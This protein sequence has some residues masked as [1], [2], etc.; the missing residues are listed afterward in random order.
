MVSRPAEEFAEWRAK[1]RTREPGPAEM[2]AGLRLAAARKAQMLE[3]MASDPARAL[4]EAI[5]RSEYAALPEALKPYFERP[6]NE[7]ASLRVMPV[8]APGPE[9]EPVRTLLAGGKTYRASVT[10]RRKTQGSKE[11]TPLAGIT[12]DGRAVLRE[13]AFE[14]LGPDDLKVLGSLPSGQAD[15]D[16]DYAS[17]A[18]LGSGQVTAMAGG[19]LYHFASGEALDAFNVRLSALDDR[20]GPLAGSRVVLAS[21]GGSGSGDGGFPWDEAE[22][23]TYKLA[24][25]WTETPKKVFFIR[26]DFP[27]LPGPS[28]SEAQLEAILNGPVATS[29]AQ[30]SYGKTSITGEAS[31]MVVRMPQPY[32]YYTA[33]EKNDQLHADASAAYEAIAGLGSLGNYDIVGVHFSSISMTSDGGL[34]AGLAILGGTKMWIQGTIAYSTFV[35]ELGHTYGLHHASFWQTTNGTVLGP[36]ATLDEYGDPF[37]VMGSGQDVTVNHYSASGKSRLNWLTPA[38]I[39]GASSAGNSGIR[40]IYRFD[41]PGTTASPRA[42]LALIPSTAD[43]YWIGYRAG[44][45]SNSSLQNGAYITLQKDGIPQTLLLDLTPGSAGG[46][47]DCALPLGKTYSDPGGG[48]HITPVA[49]GGSGADAWLDVNLQVGSFTGNTAPTLSVNAPATAVA[50]QAVSL[51][52]TASDPD[53]DPLLYQWDFGDGNTALVNGTASTGH[54]WAG[55]GTFLVKVTANDMKGH[56]STA[57]AT[58]SIT[59]PIATWTS[60]PTPIVFDVI[61]YL[62]GRFIGTSSAGYYFSADGVNWERIFRG[63]SLN[64]SPGPMA[65]DGDVFVASSTSNYFYSRDGRLW[66]AAD[67]LPTQIRMTEMVSAPGKF[68]GVAKGYSLISANQGKSWQPYPIA[69]NPDLSGVA[70]G[71]GIFVAAGRTGDFFSGFA[72]LSPALYTSPD[73]MTWTRRALPATLPYTA[74]I[75]GVQFVDGAFY[76][77]GDQT[78]ILRSNDGLNWTVVLAASEVPNGSGGTMPIRSLTHAPGF[79]IAAAGSS[80]TFSNLF[81]VSLDGQTWTRGSAA[82]PGPNPLYADGRLVSAKTHG[83]SAS[84][85]FYSTGTLQPANQAPTATVDAPVTCAARV[86]VLFRSQAT[87]PDGDPLTLLWDFNDDTAMEKTASC[88][89][90]FLVGGTYQ[91]KFRA[92]DQRGGLTTVTKT[93]TVEDPLAS[94]TKL[95]ISPP[96][97]FRSMAAGGGRIA[98]VG[99]GGGY[100]ASSDGVTWTGGKLGAGDATSIEQV[101]HDGS[102]FVACGWDRVNNT[103]KGAI[104]TSPDGVTWTRRYQDGIELYSLA[105]GGGHYAAG[106]DN[107]TILTSSDGIT[108]SPVLG[109]S[110]QPGVFY[111]MAYGDGRFLAV[112]S[113]SSAGLAMTS[114]DGTTW[115]NTSSGFGSYHPYMV[116]EAFHTGDKFLCTASESQAGFTGDILSS[117]DQGATFKRT[118]AALSYLQCF[119][120]GNGVNLCC[121]MINASNPANMISSDGIVWRF[122]PNPPPQQRTGAAYFNGRFY[123]AGQDGTIWRSGEMAP[124]AGAGYAGWAASRFPEGGPLAGPDADFDGD[125]LPNL[126]EY[127]GGSDPRDAQDHGGFTA[128]VAGDFFTMSIPKAGGVGDVACHVEYSADLGAWSGQG[129]QVVEDSSERLVARV[130]AAGRRGFLRAVFSLK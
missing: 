68:V 95:T 61:H 55:G 102:Q 25:A 72:D 70:Y 40:R 114:P 26:V 64:Y 3:W 100:Q 60:V 88:Y 53:G 27:N 98:A 45:T 21:P 107:S 39:S 28:A 110:G 74:K 19:K 41:D 9:R 92:I 101:I 46:K 24:S 20:P 12:L 94:W 122:L 84:P 42:A 11:D 90:S 51:S 86:P 103:N 82:S 81:L 126:A 66:E 67:P 5:S 59:D 116:L 18:K 111:S 48:V 79:F 2:E 34:Y 35:H 89:H 108:W 69:G 37:D 93:V 115:T 33:G 16:R 118:G 58:I 8:C 127:A 50:R 52:V 22:D 113:R 78:G 7:V 43:S 47:N 63:G 73:G 75:S 31:P 96:S 85:V 54:L 23:E 30:M 76:A 36:P 65:Y 91:V 105:A 129:V 119:A 57:S 104:Y 87:D 109:V 44:V 128:Q 29:I 32:D 97:G 83:P 130:P 77:F 124:A 13:H 123:M 1:S 112:G 6:F 17:G 56:S 121:G 99:Y 106:G 62:G 125:G 14:K 120:R 71:N 49:K 117:S 10:G 80:P 4:D 38:Q 15:P